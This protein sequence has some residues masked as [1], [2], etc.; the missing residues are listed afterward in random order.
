[1]SSQPAQNSSSATFVD[2]PATAGAGGAT[3]TKPPQ[4]STSYYKLAPS[5]TIT[6]GWNLTGLYVQP[7]A[8]TIR[9]ACANGN[10]FPVGPSDG[11]LPGNAL[12]VEWDLWS[13]QQNNPQTPLVPTSYTLMI[14]DENGKDATV[15]AG[16]FQPNS[17]L[18]FAMYTPAAYTPIADGWTCTGCNSAAVLLRLAH[19]C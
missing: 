6:F 3:I 17:N 18:K 7:S 9:A 11:V 4:T 5:Q 16:H 2:I 14:W 19:V 15:K 10:T 8:L 1:M 13:Y 12:S